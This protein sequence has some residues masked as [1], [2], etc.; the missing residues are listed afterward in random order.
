MTKQQLAGT[1]LISMICSTSIFAF[2]LDS[3]SFFITS[4]SQKVLTR[5]A[6]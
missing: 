5:L 2:V 3:I 1:V 6:D 4:L